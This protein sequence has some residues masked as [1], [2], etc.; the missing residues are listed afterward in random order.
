M[1][2]QSLLTVNSFYW[3]KMNNIYLAIDIGN[4]LV[5]AAL[6]Q[7]GRI[8]NKE[9]SAVLD[10]SLLERVLWKEKAEAAIVCS[11]RGDDQA[12]VLLDDRGIRGLLLDENT[13]LPLVNKYQSPHSLGMDRLAAASAGAALF[14]GQDV[15][16]I[17]AGTCLTFDFVNSKGEYLGGSISP[18][19]NMRLKALKHFTSRLPLIEAKQQPV[20]LTGTNTRQAILSGVING[21]LAET[22]GIIS[23]Y[24]QQYHGLAVVISGGDLIF[25]DKK[26]KN[27]I[28]A[29]ENIVLHGLNKILQYNVQ[30]SP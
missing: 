25:F 28:F 30:R 9:E 18:G 2:N 1:Q 4:T 21:I 17:C 24:K 27:R 22:E 13:P 19:L 29:V 15:L 14:P 16:V 5:K 7:D 20:P 10:E 3:R 12:L 8:L 6:F 11:V 26:L 23:S